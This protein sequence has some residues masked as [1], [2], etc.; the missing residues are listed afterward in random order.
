MS[1]LDG[2]KEKSEHVIAYISTYDDVNNMFEDAI[3][4]LK[5]LKVQ[6]KDVDTKIQEDSNLTIAQ[7]ADCNTKITNEIKKIDKHITGSITVIP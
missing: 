2:L 4:R 7:K 5:E 6:L 3:N 1:I